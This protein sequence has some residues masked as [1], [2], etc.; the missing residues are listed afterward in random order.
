MVSY[1]PGFACGLKHI[2]HNRL[3]RSQHAAAVQ[4]EEAAKDLLALNEAEKLGATYVIEQYAN[5][6]RQRRGLRILVR[7]PVDMSSSLLTCN[8][9]LAVSH[10]SA[11]LSS[12]FSVLD[13][14]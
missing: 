7:L 6:A 4:L 9:F 13:G 10:G 14:N 12:S 3:Y 8:T 11:V 2:T 1:T 5:G